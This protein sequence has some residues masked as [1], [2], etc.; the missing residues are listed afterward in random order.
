L[1]PE[2]ATTVPCWGTAYEIPAGDPEDV[3]AGLDHRERG[4]YDRSEVSLSI[5]LPDSTAVH[6]VE[7]LVYIAGPDNENYLGP[8]SIS[9]IAQQI[10]VA[11]GPSGPN[12]EYVSRLA[13]RLRE[14]DVQDAHV[15]AVEAEVNHVLA[16]KTSGFE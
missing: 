6:E 9:A 14:M 5:R 11:S 1:I 3:M 13:A 10:A 16:E 2:R 12:P 15:F 8:A 7:G 4:G